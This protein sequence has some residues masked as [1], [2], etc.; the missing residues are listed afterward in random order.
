MKKK[1]LGLLL[2]STMVFS[3]AAC[4]G[5]SDTAKDD[6][7]KDAAATDDALFMVKQTQ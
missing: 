6:S 5:N 7:S 2:A 4:G 3:L 1:L